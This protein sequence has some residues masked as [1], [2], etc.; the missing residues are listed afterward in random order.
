MS[1]LVPNVIAD[2]LDSLVDKQQRIDFC[3]FGLKG[4]K[5]SIGMDTQIANRSGFAIGLGNCDCL[6]LKILILKC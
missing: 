3:D 1:L 2:V 4:S 6:P 5:F